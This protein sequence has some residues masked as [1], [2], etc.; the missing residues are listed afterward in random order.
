MPAFLRNLT[1]EGVPV[2]RHAHIVQ[3]TLQIVSGVAAVALVI[4][5]LANIGLAIDSRNIPFGFGWL[6]TEYQTPI[7]VHFIPYD[8][9]DSYLYAL[10]VA[11]VNTLVIAVFGII[12]ATILGIIIGVARLSSNWLVSKLALV[13]VE[14]FRNVPLLVQLLFWFFIILTLPR[15]SEG[16]V[17]LDLF[18]FNNSG[19]SMPGPSGFG[20]AGIFLGWLG[21]AI[22]GIWA[23]V[24]LQ[25]KL[26]AR[27]LAL[28]GVAHP[29]MAGWAL[30]I[31]VIVGSWIILSVATGTSPIEFSTPRTRRTFRENCRG[32]HLPRSDN[33]S[34]VGAGDL[35]GGVHCG[36]STSRNPI[37]REGAGGGGQ[38]L[39]PDPHGIPTVCDIPA[40]A[41]GDYSAA[42][43]PVPEPDEEQQPGRGS[44]LSGT[45]RRGDYDDAEGV[46]AFYFHI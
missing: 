45:D 8:A 5:F 7:G 38:G 44:G 28:G 39:G 25:R 35:H 46:G 40:G 11:A 33:C 12:L 30:A 21:V 6:D 3:W 19:I 23:G 2:W 37:S 16:I 29:V 24:L 27:E 9:S 10:V 42:H 26:A 15:V 1:Y 4:W 22:L 31:A 20:G 32:N 43:Q 14:F 34:A 36:D 18:Y 41:A 17:F 13:Y